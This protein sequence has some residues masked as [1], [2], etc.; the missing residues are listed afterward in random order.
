MTVYFDK[1]AKKNGWFYVVELPPVEFNKKGHPKRRRAVKRGFITK[2]EAE[3]AERKFRNELDAGC[4]ELKKGVKFKEVI[5]YFIDYAKN[6]GKYSSGTVS[7]YEGYLNKHMEELKEVPIEN[8]TPALIAS[9]KRNL[10]KKGASDHIY[11]GCL[12]LAKSSFNYCKKMKQVTT[13]PFDDFK[14]KPIPKKLRKRFSVE[15]LIKLITTCKTKMPDFFCVFVLANCTGMRLGEYSALMPKDIQKLE[16]GCKI[17]INKQFTHNILKD[18]N[19]T[20]GSTRI[21][22]ASDKVYSVIQWHIKR[23]NILQDDFLFK[24]EEGGNIYPKWV[25]RRFHKLLKL[26]GYPED[27]CRVQDLRGQF[28]DIMHLTGAPIAHTSRQVGHSDTKITNNI[29]TQILNELPAI[30]NK[31]LDELIFSGFK[32]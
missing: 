5:I 24:A 21:V 12:K 4:I 3:A 15:E 6:E 20:I 29:Y 13:N 22:D 31:K 9:W 17:F 19:K 28:V 1:K 11:N 7:N 26:C 14:P 25:E 30:Y 8:L 27:F 16:Y 32:I 10:Y 2:K 23:Y 18:R